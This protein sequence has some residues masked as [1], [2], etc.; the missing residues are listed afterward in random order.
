MVSLSNTQMGWPTALT[1]QVSAPRQARI[2]GEF[3]LFLS[4]KKRIISNSA[5]KYR[6]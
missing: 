1:E 4:M 2:S 3:A 6:E 5:P